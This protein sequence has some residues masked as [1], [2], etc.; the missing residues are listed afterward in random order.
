MDALCL[1]CFPGW[2]RSIYS[3]IT[4]YKERRWR[5]VR[6]IK[7]KTWL[8]K[9]EKLSG[10]KSPCSNGLHLKLLKELKNNVAKLPPKNVSTPSIKEEGDEC[11]SIFKNSS[12]LLVRLDFNKKTWCC[13]EFFKSLKNSVFFPLWKLCTFTI[14]CFWKSFSTHSL[15]FLFCLFCCCCFCFNF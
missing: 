10:H 14:S 8:K 11:P 6:E 12:V 5:T 9:Y 13:L 2:W 15:C 1:A 3:G 7:T 4:L